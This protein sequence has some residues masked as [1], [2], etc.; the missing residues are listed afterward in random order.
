MGMFF[1][2]LWLI[3]LCWCFAGAVRP[4]LTGP[5]GWGVAGPD[6]V[7]GDPCDGPFSICGVL[8]WPFLI[9]KLLF[10][11]AEVRAPSRGW[12]GATSI[13][14][15]RVICRGA[16]SVSVCVWL[17]LKARVRGL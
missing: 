14:Y 3:G 8:L 12:V 17:K 4:F 5:A 9:V 15:R 16:S 7:F 11:S 10:P 2:L 6:F 1:A 13:W